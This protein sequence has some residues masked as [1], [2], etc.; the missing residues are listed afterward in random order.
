[1]LKNPSSLRKAV[2]AAFSSFRLK[3][4]PFEPPLELEEEPHPAKISAASG[5]N[6]AL[7]MI[8]TSRNPLN[9]MIPGSLAFQIE[10]KANFWAVA[11]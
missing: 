7:A 4:G 11:P 1:M 2:A 3:S 6:A 9:P 10:A 8:G 5:K